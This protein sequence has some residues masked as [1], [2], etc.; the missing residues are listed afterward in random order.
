MRVRTRL[1]IEIA[2]LAA[3]CTAV[4]LVFSGPRMRVQP[5][6]RALERVPPPAPAGRVPVEAPSW[7]RGFPSDDRGA[8]A[9]AGAIFYGYYCA[10]CHGTTGDGAGPVGR[11]YVPTPTDLRAWPASKFDDAEV[12]R[13]MLS[14]RGHAPVLERVVLPEARPDLVGYVRRLA[15][16]APDGAR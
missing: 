4:Y 1:L 12:A 11:S 15:G 8:D 10:F 13:R 6:V 9:S 7:R 14:G 3:A 5:N 16:H 2:L